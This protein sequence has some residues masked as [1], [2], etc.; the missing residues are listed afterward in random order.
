[1][2]GWK[3]WRE[4]FAQTNVLPNCLQYFWTSHRQL[5]DGTFKRWVRHQKTTGSPDV[6]ILFDP[7]CS[8]DIPQC[9]FEKEKREGWNGTLNTLSC[10]LKAQDSGLSN[11]CFYFWVGSVLTSQ[12]MPLPKLGSAGVVIFDD[13][14]YLYQSESMMGISIRDIGTEMF[15]RF[16]FVWE[17]WEIYRHSRV[18]TW[19]KWTDKASSIAMKDWIE[20]ISC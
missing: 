19:R 4:V 18:I 5:L 3:K 1:M 8:W 14:W 12:L 17:V 10:F 20:T 7:S 9:C 15:P 13:I 11:V 2:F 16:H 6:Y